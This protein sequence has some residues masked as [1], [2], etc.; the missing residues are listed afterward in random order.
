MKIV[1]VGEEGPIGPLIVSTLNERGHQ[2]VAAAAA[3]DQDGLADCELTQMLSG[4]GAVID[5]A[6]SPSHDGRTAWNFFTRATVNLV[7]AAHLAAVPHV[8]AL[9][10]VGTGG[11]LSS[12]YFRAKARHEQLVSRV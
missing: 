10:A 7:N 6:E 9:S 8:V 2:A 12:G 11:L 1:V 3:S 5:V 4:A